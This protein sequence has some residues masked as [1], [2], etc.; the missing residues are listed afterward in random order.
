M[1]AKKIIGEALVCIFLLAIL[2]IV[3]YVSPAY[4]IH[5][6]AEHTTQANPL[7]SQAA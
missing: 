7:T 1:G 5:L 6:K 2:G 3:A 4:H